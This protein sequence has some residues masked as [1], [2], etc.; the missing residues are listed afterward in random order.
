M[1]DPDRIS[2][3][4]KELDPEVTKIRKNKE[5]IDNG[6]DNRNK[7]STDEHTDFKIHDF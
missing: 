6:D 2:K 5:Q 4:Q 7:G 1:E 3:E